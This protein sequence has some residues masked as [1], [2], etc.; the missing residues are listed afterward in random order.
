MVLVPVKEQSSSGHC[1]RAD[2]AAGP[3]AVL[4]AHVNACSEQC[5]VPF[6]MSVFP[7]AENLALKQSCAAPVCSLRMVLQVSHSVQG[8]KRC[9]WCQMPGHAETRPKGCCRT[10][11]V[12][13]PLPL[14]VGV[15]GTVSLLPGKASPGT[16]GGIG[17]PEGTKQ[18]LKAS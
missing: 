9:P 13:N 12:S 2:P 14:E 16:R 17:G 15:K 6:F 1:Q 4:C 10:G 8:Q 11:H 18:S 7:G 5:Q 3:S